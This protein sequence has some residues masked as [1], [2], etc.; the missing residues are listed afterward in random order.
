MVRKLS[1][2]NKTGMCNIAHR[3]FVNRNKGNKYIRKGEMEGA[4][5]TPQSS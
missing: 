4:K 3:K 2:T 1:G 5:D